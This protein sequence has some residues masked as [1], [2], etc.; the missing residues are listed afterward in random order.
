MHNNGAKGKSQPSPLKDLEHFNDNSFAKKDWETRKTVAAALEGAGRGRPGEG[1]RGG[2]PASV[3][4]VA[5]P[6]AREMR[7]L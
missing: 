2:R 7:D 6:A 4:R 5:A 1:A 3:S